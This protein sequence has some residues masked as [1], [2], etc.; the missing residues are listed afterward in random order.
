MKIGK[1]ID[2]AEVGHKG[3]IQQSSALLLSLKNAYR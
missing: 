2:K 3:N 1:S